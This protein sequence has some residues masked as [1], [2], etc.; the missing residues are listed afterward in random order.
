MIIR[1]E[2]CNII[3]DKV[4]VEDLDHYL[5]V[6]NMDFVENIALHDNTGF[7]EIGY[8]ERIREVYYRVN[9]V[10]KYGAEREYSA[11]DTQLFI[12]YDVLFYD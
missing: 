5:E 2:K 8:R 11:L 6:G 12:N 9:V 3:F 10:M 4:T 1:I 7:K